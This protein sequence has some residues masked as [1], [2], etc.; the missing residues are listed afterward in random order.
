MSKGG[1]SV[2]KTRKKKKE[3]RQKERE[4]RK[5]KEGERNKNRTN[6]MNVKES[7]RVYEVILIMLTDFAWIILI[8]FSLFSH[9]SKFYQRIFSPQG[10]G[11]S[12]EK[13]CLF[14]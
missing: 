5:E 9:I 7:V 12:G 3:E 2:G 14:L 10:M 8:I 4:G 6:C 1:Q 13:D 11:T